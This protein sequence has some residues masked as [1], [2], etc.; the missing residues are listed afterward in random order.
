MLLA[1][2]ATVLTQADTPIERLYDYLDTA[3]HLTM[4]VK[5]GAKGNPVAGEAQY[6]WIWPNRQRIAIGTGSNIVEFRQNPKFVHVVDHARKAYVEYTSPP[7][8]SNPPDEGADLMNFYPNY[9][10]FIK[11]DDKREIP[12]KNLG[13]ATIEGTSYDHVQVA[14]EGATP[15]D[16]F[17]DSLGRI[18]R[19]N[20]TVMTPGGPQEFYSLFENYDLSQTKAKIKSE[21]EPGY[22]PDKIPDL[23]NPILAGYP[24]E[25]GKVK[26][27]RSNRE[28]DLDKERGNSHLAVLITSPDCIPSQK[29]ENAW[30]NLEKALKAKGVKF[31]EVV[32]GGTP[33]LKQKGSRPIYLDSNGTVEENVSPPVTPYIVMV[34]GK[35][36]MRQGWAG[37]APDQEKRM[38]ETLVNRIEE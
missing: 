24:L 7:F 1:A 36:I 15:V 34:D 8:L 29:G 21:I 30:Q 11:S 26:N 37:Y 13:K 10:L 14:E 9:H 18:R 22:V 23:H 31:V 20:F 12:F 6:T 35:G 3:D 19:V 2:L 5:F 4:T 27:A 32:V 33:D 38:V 28:V 16:F 17:L 25:F